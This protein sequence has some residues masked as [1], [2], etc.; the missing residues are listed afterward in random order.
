M[1]RSATALKP[2]Q[3][4]HFRYDCVRQVMLVDK[5]SAGVWNTNGVFQ[6]IPAMSHSLHWSGTD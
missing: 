4:G 3:S 2:F 1:T 6:D 5:R